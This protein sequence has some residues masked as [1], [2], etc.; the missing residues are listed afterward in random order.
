MKA[1]IQDD[2][3]SEPREI[4]TDFHLR[5]VDERGEWIELSVSGTMAKIY[6]S[7]L[8]VI[9]PHSGNA[10]SVRSERFNERAD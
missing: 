9:R 4:S 10:I 2:I 5:V 1:F 3:L 7:R 6:G 8:L